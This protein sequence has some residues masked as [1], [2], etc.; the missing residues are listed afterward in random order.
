MSYLEFKI[1]STKNIK[2]IVLV[3]GHIHEEHAEILKTRL[4]NI[5]LTLKQIHNRIFET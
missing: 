3:R 5:I 4:G 1:K 2:R